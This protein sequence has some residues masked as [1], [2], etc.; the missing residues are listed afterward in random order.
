MWMQVFFIYAEMFIFY[1]ML[2]NCFSDY[3]KI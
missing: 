1:A 2:K 3:Y